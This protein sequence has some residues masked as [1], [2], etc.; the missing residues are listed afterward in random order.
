[1]LSILFTFGILASAITVNKI[2]LFTMAPTLL[3]GI[4]MFFA[5]IILA[6]YTYFFAKERLHLARIKKYLLILILITACSTY[7][8][9]ILKAYGLQKM[10]SSKAAFFGSLE[11]FIAA[12]FAYIF[13]G[14]TLNL[15]KISGILL[16]FAGALVM[17]IA[18]DR[19]ENQMMAFAFISWPEIAVISAI[20]MSRFGWTLIAK[21]LK[22]KIFSPTEINTITMLISGTLSLFTAFSLGQT[23]V[24]SLE[25][26]PY[27]ILKAF[28]FNDLNPNTSLLIFLIYTII[29]GNLIAYNLYAHVLKKYSV[30][31]VALVGFSVPLFVH[32]Y[33]WLFLSENLSTRF[34]I[35]SLFTFMGLCIF[36]IQETKNNK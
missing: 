4:R 13:L 28:P 5:G 1:M 18:P 8:P 3:V 24:T 30:T 33:G 9:S 27:S 34:F 2:I 36:F 17:L 15:H 23:D 12:V 7:L 21:Y 35:S 14:E 11:P 22:D 26:A 32:I 20:I 19:F 25:G 31:F 10:V 16:G 6:M 29:V